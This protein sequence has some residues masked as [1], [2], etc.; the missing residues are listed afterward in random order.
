[1]VEGVVSSPFVHGAKEFLDVFSRR[2]PMFVVSATPEEELR[3]IISRR[4]LEGYFRGIYGAPTTKT[5]AISEILERTGSTRGETLFVGD[6]VNDLNA[7][8]SCGIRFV[9]R[10]P[11]DD[12]GRFAGDAGVE[13]VVADLAGLSRYLEGKPC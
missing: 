8:R 6:A 10:Q 11:P 4:G 2:F 9:G 5:D 12:P 1:V 3:S 7:A 13:A